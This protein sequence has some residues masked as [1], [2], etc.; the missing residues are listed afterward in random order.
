[1]LKAM[2]IELDAIAREISVS[3]IVPTL[4]LMIFTLTPSTSNLFK[5][6]QR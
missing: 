5:E 2:M 6:I 3:V 1:M 4:L